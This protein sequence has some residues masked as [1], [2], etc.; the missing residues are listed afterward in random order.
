[1]KLYK[2][3]ITLLLPVLLAGCGEEIDLVS[4]TY[5]DIAGVYRLESMKFKEPR[6]VD[7][8]GDGISSEDIISELMKFQAFAMN[9]DQMNPI[10]KGGDMGSGCDMTE[11]NAS[12]KINIRMCLQAYDDSAYGDVRTEW[13]FCD[14]D[15]TIKPNGFLSVEPYEKDGIRG[16]ISFP[17]Q[18][19]MIFTIDYGFYDFS[20]HGIC[21]YESEWR[22]ERI[23]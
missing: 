23:R 7:L 6:A 2:T 17:M 3:I 22:Y 8:N 5:Y 18:D 10:V 13:L 21:N 19:V 9:L 20:E 16:E 4:E 12:G 14:L 15:F 11:I 1:M